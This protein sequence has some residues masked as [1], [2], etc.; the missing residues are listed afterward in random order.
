MGGFELDKTSSTI[1][2][3]RGIDEDA[4]EVSGSQNISQGTGWAEF[5]FHIDPPFDPDIDEHSRDA[6]YW[7]DVSVVS[8]TDT[9]NDFDFYFIYDTTSP[10]VP[11]FGITSFHPSSGTMIVSGKTWPDSSDPQQV[12]IFLNGGSQGVIAADGAGNF[13]MDNLILASGD[14]YIAVQS[15]DRAGNKSSLSGSLRQEYNPESLLSIVIRSSHVVKSG[16]ATIPVTI[17]YSVTE[18]AQVTIHIYNL[19]GET[20]KEWSEWVNPGAEP[21]WSWLGDNMYGET[22]NNGVYILK[23]IAD[24]GVGRRENVAKLLGVLR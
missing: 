18:L 12:E 5:I 17:I 22:V 11:D 6:L 1:M 16:S 15:T 19:L 10:A 14:N 7:L 3:F 20:I 23:V 24:N 2:L 21:E 4:E 8:T 9:I 13:S